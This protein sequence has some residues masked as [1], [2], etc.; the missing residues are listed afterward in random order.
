[1][2]DNALNNKLYFCGDKI[3]GYD[4]QL[5]CEIKSLVVCAD[6]SFS[7]ELNKKPNIANWI[8]RINELPEVAPQDR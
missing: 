7:E 6:A 8:R 4:L 3:T 5:Y 1:M 2:L